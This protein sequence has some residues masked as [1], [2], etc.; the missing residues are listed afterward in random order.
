MIKNLLIGTASLVS[1]SDTISRAT[2]PD[3]D[4]KVV[5]DLF[6]ES[7]CPYCKRTITGSFHEAFKAEGFLEM[8]TVNMYPYGNARETEVENGWEFECQ[9]GA[10]ECNY[11]MLETCGLEYI[12]DAYT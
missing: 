6:F 8:A 12:P 9:H 10:E 3:A 2:D 1:A 5:I 4:Q 11:N 7:E